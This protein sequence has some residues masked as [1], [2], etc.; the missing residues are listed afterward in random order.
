MEEAASSL[1]FGILGVGFAHDH[2]VLQSACSQIRAASSMVGTPISSRA[3]SKNLCTASL[4]L[5]MAS[6]RDRVATPD[7]STPCSSLR[8]AASAKS[9]AVPRGRPRPP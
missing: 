6:A 8:S 3:E 1:L 5:P 7:G 2:E 9:K 4:P